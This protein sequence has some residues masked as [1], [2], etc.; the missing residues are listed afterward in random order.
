MPFDPRS[1]PPYTVIRVPVVLNGVLE[2]KRFV[3]ISHFNSSAL[4]IKPT[5]GVQRFQSNK[6]LAAGV[7]MYDAGEVAVFELPTVVDPGNQFAILHK[8]LIDYHTNGEL[9][10]L[11]TLPPEFEADLRDAIDDS[12][13]LS[14]V[15]KKRLKSQLPPHP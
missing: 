7:V 1:I 15:K 10:I 8:Q 5:S 3:V 2:R 6:N 13:E 9:E 4:V 12:I 11:G 14:L